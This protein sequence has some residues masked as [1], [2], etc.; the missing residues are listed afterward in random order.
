MKMSGLPANFGVPAAGTSRTGATD[1][2]TIS[3]PPDLA[4]KVVYPG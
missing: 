4:V 1:R 2:S 3:Y